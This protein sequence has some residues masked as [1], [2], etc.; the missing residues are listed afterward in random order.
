MSLGTTVRISEVK[1]VLETNSTDLGAL[2]TNPSINPWSKWKPIA[3]TEVTLTLEH[4][5]YMNYGITMLYHTSPR[6]LYDLVLENDNIGFIYNKPT[7]LGGTLF[8]LGDFRNYN[9]NA[10]NPI[11]PFFNDG[12]EIKIKGVSSD[13][14]VDIIGIE[15]PD[16]GDLDSTDYLTKFH[17]YPSGSEWT[18]G[19]LIIDSEGNYQWA[20]GCIPWGD[21]YFQRFKSKTCTVM[22]FMSN[23]PYGTYSTN[24]ESGS[25]SDLFYAIPNSSIH[26]I[27]VLDSS[28]SGS[29]DVFID[30]SFFGGGIFITQDSSKVN[31]MF[32]YSSIGDVYS[33]GT[34]NNLFVGIYR[35]KDCIDVIAQTRLNDGEPLSVGTEEASRMFTGS[36][37][38]STLSM[39]VWV[40][41]HWDNKLQHVTMPM[42]QP[43]LEGGDPLDPYNSE[44]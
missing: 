33:G 44:E 34:L 3:S 31:Y 24:Y 8:R 9:H 38:N 32:K 37:N 26:T 5:K 6:S 27:S 12:D 11:E 1:E 42:L 36:L 35:D 10:F 21:T 19:A 15:A 25:S 28:P 13:Y 22:E 4:L 2:C 43:S 23:L 17:I 7:G 14:T 40:G 29:K 18:R 20:I 39:E 41:F 30:T 16:P